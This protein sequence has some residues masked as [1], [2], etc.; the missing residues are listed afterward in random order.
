MRAH[1]I[2]ASL[3]VLAG[4]SLG[5]EGRSPAAPSPGGGLTQPT[6]PAGFLAAPSVRMISPKVGATSGATLVSI[7]G[8]GF[9]SG[10]TVTI[11]GAA[12]SLVAVTG[13]TITATTRPGDAGTVDV[14]VTNPD[15]QRGVLREGYTYAVA[16]AGPPPSITAISPNVGIAGGG[17]YVVITGSGFHFGT[18]VTLDG[19]AIRVNVHDGA[20]YLQTPPHAVGDVDLVVTNPDGTGAT[21]R[22]GFTFVLPESLDLNGTWEGLAGEHYD[23][24][25]RF[26]IEKNALT[27][28]SCGSAAE[29]TFSA[30]PSTRAGEFSTSGDGMSMQGKFFSPGYGVGRIN[31]AACA[32]TVWEAWKR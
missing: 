24:V 21:R 16:P 7:A 25:L 12:A 4:V 1:A 5:C 19:V 18:T 20:I 9:Q 30:P 28:F 2:I 15:G 31:S 32:S 8:A 22:G 23:F 14:V 29:V 11:G 6:P 27:R 26:T 17:T 10:V 13:D 3:L